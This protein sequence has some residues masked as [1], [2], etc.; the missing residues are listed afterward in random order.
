[1]FDEARR[2]IQDQRRRGQCHAEE[3]KEGREPS[4]LA[5]VIQR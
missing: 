5:A 3:Q 4:Y 2:G 1:M